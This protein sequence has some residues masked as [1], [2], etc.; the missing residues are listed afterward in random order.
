MPGKNLKNI[1]LNKVT[2]GKDE[3]DNNQREKVPPSADAQIPSIPPGTFYGGV[4]VCNN[5]NKQEKDNLNKQE[6]DNLNSET[7]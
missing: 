2:G 5:L 1:D 7:S 4:T 3:K 6:K